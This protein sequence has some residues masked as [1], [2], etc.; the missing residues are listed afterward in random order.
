MCGIAGIFNYNT[1]AETL[2]NEIG[3]LLN[4]DLTSEDTE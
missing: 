3:D 4:E 1:S 2:N